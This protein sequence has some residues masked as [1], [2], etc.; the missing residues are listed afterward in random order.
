MSKYIDDAEPQVNQYGRNMVMTNVG[1]SE[2]KRKYVNLDTKFRDEYAYN[3]LAN[4]TYISL[5]NYTITLPERLTNVKS[6][7][8]CNVEI[9]LSFYN[10][11][12]NLGN[13]CFSITYEGVA[14]PVIIPDGEYTTASLSSI[15]NT[16][17]QLLTTN[18]KTLKHSV[19]NNFSVFDCSSGSLTVNFDVNSTGIF[20]KYNFKSKL[21]WL[22]GFRKQ[23]YTIT[24]A[25][26][27]S[28]CFINLYGPKY[29]Y[30]VIDEFSQKNPNSFIS[31]QSG[32]LMSK[33]ILARIAMNSTSFPFGSILPANNFNGFL[34]TD[35]RNYGGAIDIKKFNVQLVNEIGIPMNLNGLD[36]SF[37]LEVEHE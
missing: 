8:V 34:L 27:K 7:M 35:K 20:D 19:I 24:N 21:G 26:T 16:Q 10:I 15:I 23:Q 11:S 37:C 4:N 33:N 12:E 30:L 36:F 31:P 3:S 29:L 5:A 1:H 22:L 2:S 17:I 28:E 13:N 32:F 18:Y 9:P 14:Q 25:P 6:I